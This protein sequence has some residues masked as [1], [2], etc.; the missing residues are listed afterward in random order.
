M[1][2]SLSIG[3]SIHLCE[4]PFVSSLLWWLHVTQSFLSY[5]DANIGLE[6]NF[7]WWLLQTLSTCYFNRVYIYIYIKKR[8]YSFVYLF[9]MNVWEQCITNMLL[10][11]A[12]LL[13][14][15]TVSLKIHA[16]RHFTRRSVLT[17]HEL[18]C[19]I[20]LNSDFFWA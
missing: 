8:V 2:D 19:E 20:M 11:Y 6:F 16:C 3:V 13:L 9:S 4:R 17:A 5:T 18:H 1:F 7:P 10:K 15:K 14:F 12:F